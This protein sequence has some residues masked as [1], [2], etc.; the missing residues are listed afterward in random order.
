MQRV[1]MGLLLFFEL[2]CAGLL[3]VNVVSGNIG[4]TSAAVAGALAIVPAVAACAI[5]PR[6]W[7]SRT[8]MGMALFFELS[9]SS[10]F[11]FS[12][13]GGGL[14]ANAGFFV[15]LFGAI[16][17]GSVV[18]TG[19]LS[20]DLMGRVQ[21]GLVLM[22]EISIVALFA[23]AVAYGRFDQSVFFFV[24]IFGIIGMV[25]I[26]LMV[27]FPPKWLRAAVTHGALLVG[28]IVF[29]FPF[30]WLVMTSFKYDE[31]VMVYPPKWIPSVPGCI[32]Q[33]PYLTAEDY[34]AVERPRELTAERWAQVWPKLE[35]AIWLKGREVLGDE[36][37]A[38]FD[39]AILR[40]TLIR[41]LWDAGSKGVPR[42]AW[43][44]TDHVIIA[45]VT[46]RIDEG[47]VEDVWGTIRRCVGLRELRV[48]DTRL[49]E[50]RLGD[51]E[52][53]YLDLWR[54][55]EGDIRCIRHGD[56]GDLPL[57]IEYS[58]S[59]GDHVALVADLPLP[60]E[61]DDFLS[62]TIPMQQDRSWHSLKFELEM[63]GKR[64]VP[65]DNL[66]LGRRTS[67][68]ITF[69]IKDRDPYELDERDLGIW[70][71]VPSRKPSDFDGPG[72]FRLTIGI[73]RSSAFG[74]AW[75][76]YTDSYRQA[77]I[78]T[79]YR[80]HYLFNSVY[81]V[82]LNVVGQVL[83]C[84]LVAYAFARLKWP[85]RD[86]LFAVLLATMMLPPQVT[87]VPVFVVF[88]HLHWYNTLKALGAPSF[89]GSAFFIFLLRQFMRTIPT[90]REDAAKID[91]CGYFG[92]YWRIILPLL[93][94]ALAAV[95][96]F[97]F[98]GTW[99]NFMGPLIY[100]NDQRLYP[101]ALGLFEFRTEHGAQYGM[102]MAASTMMIVPVVAIFFLAQRHFIQGVTLT[103]MKG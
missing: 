40:R 101:L 16:G 84:S 59:K 20:G 100:I 1:V 83:S 42:E 46:K 61:P 62:V 11:A 51:E 41:G 69:K 86:V 54:P 78:S 15:T 3:A 94:P 52:R 79:K 89:L 2:F 8:L 58:F 91:G 53:N 5:I 4:T 63:N 68:E 32:E 71:L 67:Q 56:E 21:M 96:I 29:S 38:G 82:I 43:S 27:V 37:A 92:V 39:D 6:R 81:L 76:K 97:T 9:L 99:N 75:H 93:K 64:Y 49:V 65:E 12:V 10:L 47:R 22:L 103:G 66:Y 73:E 98:M 30:I 28:C 70:P 19:L 25:S 33:S 36:R 55:A 31:E 23:V 74:A 50:R 60:I 57:S 35:E 85:G 88:K 45:A 34:Q 90:E 87:M 48:K 72:R 26:S 14:P 17:L 102:L 24:Y 95:A 80:W 44:D 13:I 18:V 77:Y 7:L